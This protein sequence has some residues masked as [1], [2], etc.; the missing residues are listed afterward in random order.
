MARWL[1]S[2][3]KHLKRRCAWLQFHLACPFGNCVRAEWLSEADNSFLLHSR[4]ADD[5]QIYGWRVW[6]RPWGRCTYGGPTLEDRD[7]MFLGAWLAGAD[8]EWRP[9][10]ANMQRCRLGVFWPALL[11]TPSWALSLTKPHSVD[12]DEFRAHGSQHCSRLSQQVAYTKRTVKGSVISTASSTAHLLKQGALLLQT[13]CVAV[14]NVPSSFSPRRGRVPEIIPCR[15][16]IIS[17][18]SVYIMTLSF[19]INLELALRW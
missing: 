3:S 2:V 16:A 18:Q 19:R 17:T 7:R 12:G 10:E 15:G 14:R 13:K 4:R 5:R 8:I 6:N 11:V 9:G 1:P